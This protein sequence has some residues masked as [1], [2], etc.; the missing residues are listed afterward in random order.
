MADLQARLI[1]A[2]QVMERDYWKL[3]DIE[4]RY[5]LVFDTSS[6]P[7]LLVRASNLHILEANVAA[8]QVFGFSPAG[9]DLLP[10]LEPQ[11]RESFQS[12]LFRVRENGKAPAV[13][14]HLGQDRAPWMV[15]GSLMTAEPGHIYM[16]QLTLA[17]VG[18]PRIDL[19]EDI[20][21]DRLFEYAP[22]AMILVDRDGVLR[23][24]NRAFLDLV[25]VGAEG[26]VLGER[27]SSW[28][29]RP[30]ADHTVLLATVCK[31]GVV[32][33]F[34]TT[35]HGEL[36]AN[37][38][39]E[40][41]AAYGNDDE[42]RF[43]AMVL[44]DI[45]QRLPGPKIDDRMNATVESLTE[46]VGKT[47]LRDLVRDTVGMVERR[48]LEAALELTNG[49]RTA[50]AELLGLSRQGLY[51]KLNRYGLHAASERRPVRSTCTSRC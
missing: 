35:V 22:D 43:I 47:P 34:S 3:R 28:L 7:I 17:G 48:Y 2:Q 31:Q 9:K 41:S 14:V 30:G 15:R 20:P 37:T 11:E 38:D 16:L 19:N 23:R 4:T 44:R 46:Q 18:Q 6:E 32:R 51:A 13:L 39:V 36:G 10:E 5:R 49:N 27:L 33:L 26:Y 12:M 29:E 42:P 8:I 24:A 45:W 21:L 50:A 25:Q 40:I 1:E